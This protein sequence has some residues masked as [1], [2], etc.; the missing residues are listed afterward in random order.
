M[1]RSLEPFVCYLNQ[2]VA[3]NLLADVWAVRPQ[4]F[5]LDVAIVTPGLCRCVSQ[6]SGARDLRQLEK[7]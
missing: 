4:P 1:D 6:N 5:K 2:G 7:E 3:P